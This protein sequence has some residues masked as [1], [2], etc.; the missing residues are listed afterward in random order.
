[1]KAAARME[2]GAEHA[3]VGPAEQRGVAAAA[4]LLPA[5]AP[6]HDAHRK[7][8]GATADIGGGQMEP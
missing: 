6:P 1:M 2:D 5:A 4:L 3:P 7:A 8:K